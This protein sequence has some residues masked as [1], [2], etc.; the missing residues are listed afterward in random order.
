[1]T[2]KEIN[3]VLEEA[4]SL[5]TESHQV[6]VYFKYGNNFEVTDTLTSY[7]RNDLAERNGY[8]LEYIFKA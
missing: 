2:E 7:H 3:R 1:M 5:L 4:E 6:L 8:Y